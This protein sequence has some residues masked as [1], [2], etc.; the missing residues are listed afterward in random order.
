MAALVFVRERFVQCR[1]LR[2][3]NRFGAHIG[4]KFSLAHGSPDLFRV[5]MPFEIVYQSLAF[6]RKRLAHETEE[7]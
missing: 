3:F 7:R 4:W 1:H 2:K 6:L 5:E